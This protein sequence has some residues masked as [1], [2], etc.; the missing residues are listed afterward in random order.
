MTSLNVGGIPGA[1]NPITAEGVCVS[2]AC[3]EVPEQ[4]VTRVTLNEKLRLLI[5]R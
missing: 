5:C 1:A 4:T 3:A 2:E